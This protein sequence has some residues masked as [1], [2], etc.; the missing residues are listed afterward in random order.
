MHEHFIAG[1][2]PPGAGPSGIPPPPTKFTANPEGLCPHGPGMHE[3]FNALPPPQPLNPNRNGHI[4]QDVCDRTHSRNDP[5]N[6][7]E[8]RNYLKG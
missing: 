4:T 2:G 1:S 3:R 5:I 8:E 7:Q 6:R